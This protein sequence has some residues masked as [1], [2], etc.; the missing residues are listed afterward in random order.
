MLNSSRNFLVIIL[1]LNIL[2]IKL[3][4]NI[5]KKHIPKSRVSFYLKSGIFHEPG[6]PKDTQTLCWLRPC[7]V[8]DTGIWNIPEMDQTGGQAV[9]VFFQ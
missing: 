7:S 3:W 6:S 1:K 8:R 2:E 5:Y 4:I 9:K